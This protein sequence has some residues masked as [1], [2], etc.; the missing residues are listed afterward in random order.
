MYALYIGS[1][2]LDPSAPA[3]TSATCLVVVRRWPTT[4]DQGNLDI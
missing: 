2:Y 3:D 1:Y 4:Y